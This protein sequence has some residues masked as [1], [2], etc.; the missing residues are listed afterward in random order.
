MIAAP[1]QFL[2][3]VLATFVL[4]DAAAIAAGVLA[5]DGRLSL[6]FAV[7]ACAIGIWI[8]DLVLFALGRFGGAALLRTR[9][10]RRLATTDAA[11][12][13]AA[14][15]QHAGL[16]IVGSRFV[17]GTR[18][19]TYVG[20]GL[21][22]LSA[23][24]FAAWTALGCLVWTPILVVTI[25]I[26][27]RAVADPLQV[28]LGGAWI[29]LPVCLWIAWLLRG[30]VRSLRVTLARLMRWEFWP[31]WLFYAPV[32]PWVVWLIA[33]H[34]ARAIAAANPG[35]ED[36][37]FTGESKSAIL[38]KLPREWTLPHVVV[39]AGESLPAGIALPVILKP[40]VGQRGA[41]VLL[42]RTR[43]EAAAYLSAATSTVIAQEYHAGPY[44]AGVFY[45]RRPHESQGRIFS[46]T[47]KRFPSLVGDGEHTVAEL[48]ASHPRFRLQQPLFRRRLAAVLVTVPRAGAL[49][50]LGDLGNH[51]QGAIFLDGSDLITPALTARIDALAREID[52]F[53]I[54]RFD[55]RYRDP[56]AFMAGEDLAIVELNGVT[57]EATHIYDP[58]LSLWNAYRTLFEQWQL[59]FEIGAA[60]LR[61]GEKGTSLGR[62]LTLSGRH[63]MT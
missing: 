58:S 55:I 17:P 16:A 14:L 24:V 4:E 25:A 27:G 33:R 12:A 2:T 11:R 18:L 52:G 31:Q 60:N 28:Y 3:V 53:Y 47:E 44:E 39:A 20:A 10:G 40:D 61:R 7:S 45:V 13:S 23:P 22:G 43:E 50:R 32:V 41:G 26:F 1:L 21:A 15:K 54:G 34:G 63:L 42:A 38:E 8:G 19:P 48:I 62:L 30:R 49:V 59:V 35:L 9:L 46:I 56:R 5:A 36:G 51:A 37:G 6:A 57:S 29:A